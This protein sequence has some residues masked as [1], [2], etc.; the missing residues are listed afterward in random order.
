MFT[1]WRKKYILSTKSD[2]CIF[3]ADESKDEEN[4]VVY[5][6]EYCFV[7]INKYPYNNGHLMVVPNRHIKQL[8]DLAEVEMT[9]L[10]N[11][12]KLTEKV[13]IKEYNPEGINIGINIG[14]AA[15]AGIDEHLHVHLVPRWNGDTNFMT[16]ISETRVIPEDLNETYNLVKNQFNNVVKG[17]SCE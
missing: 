5:R 3:C 6:S 10:F 16:T 8:N 14:K 15:G 13:I 2:K 12:V 4:M 7:I 17:N 1:P 11:I 9:D